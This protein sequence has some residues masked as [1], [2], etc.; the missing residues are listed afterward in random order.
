MTRLLRALSI[1]LLAALAVAV[2]G[3]GSTGTKASSSS[4]S[5][6]KLVRSGVVAFVTVNSDLESSQWKQLDELAK[7][8]PGRDK[9]LARIRQA[10]AKQGVVF[11]DDVEPALGPE[12]DLAVALGIGDRGTAVVA[13]TKPDDPDKLKA[14]VAKLNASDSAGEKAVY[15]EVDGWYALSDQQASIDR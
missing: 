6:A 4:E 15:R 13:L 10:F 14:L 9:V 5:G 11:K 2:S 12:V 7:K 3:C 8:F 1:A